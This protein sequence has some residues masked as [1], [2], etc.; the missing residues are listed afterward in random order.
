MNP[1]RSNTLVLLAALLIGCSA[2]QS[3]TSNTTLTTPPSET[4][5]AA[6]SEPAEAS[7]PIVD[8]ADAEALTAPSQEP[9]AVMDAAV[10][11]GDAA[12][13]A[14]REAATR[15]TSTRSAGTVSSTSNTSS[16]SVTASPAVAE[17]RAVFD[18]SCGRC[19]PGGE[20]RVGPRLAGRNDS[21]AHLRDVVRNGD[22]T[23]RP[24]PAA[25]LSDGDLAK[26]L[27]FLRS[28]RAVR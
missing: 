28:I 10:V 22:G 23:M 1:R 21:E 4:P 24:I 5:D 11:H 19:H 20:R 3:T 25:R 17:G 16:T 27:T 15:A 6:T 7:A 12:A 26:V 18:R 9:P 14:A 8:T 13:D 2:N